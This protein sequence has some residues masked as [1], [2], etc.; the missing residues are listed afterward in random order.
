MGVITE[1]KVIR[2]SVPNLIEDFTYALEVEDYE[3]CQ[4]LKDHLL[5]EFSSYSDT[6]KEKFAMYLQ[7]Y[8]IRKEIDNTKDLNGLFNEILDTLDS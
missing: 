2:L 3:A 7:E 1:V 4:M 8:L 5:G 6:L